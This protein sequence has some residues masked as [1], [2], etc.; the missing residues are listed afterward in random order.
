M[1]DAILFTANDL[2]NLIWK[3]D[4]VL[5]LFLVKELNLFQQTQSFELN[6]LFYCQFCSKVNGSKA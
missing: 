3:V 4:K 5:F 6:A 2:K 1:N